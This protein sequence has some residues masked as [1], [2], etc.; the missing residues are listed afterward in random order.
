MQNPLYSNYGITRSLARYLLPLKHSKF[1]AFLTFSNSFSENNKS[2]KIET[3]LHVNT[4]ELIAYNISIAII[5]TK[6][7]YYDM[8]STAFDE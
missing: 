2:F 1:K 3:I 5:K 4:T 7:G 8:S 6:R